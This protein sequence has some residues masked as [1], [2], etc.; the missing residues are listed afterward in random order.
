MRDYT[1]NSAF[2]I[3]QKCKEQ[4]ITLDNVV[5]ILKNNLNE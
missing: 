1:V 2:P 5:D 3:Y 4:G